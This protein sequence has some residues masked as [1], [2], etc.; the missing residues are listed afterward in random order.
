MGNQKELR[1]RIT[2]LKTLP[3]AVLE[4]KTVVNQT[5]GRRK[6]GTLRCV[7]S[8]HESFLKEENLYVR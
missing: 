4:R 6:R 5:K 8:Y 3:V 1:L 2:V 7:P